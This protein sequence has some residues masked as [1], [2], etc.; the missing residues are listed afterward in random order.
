[1]TFPYICQTAV[2]IPVRVTDTVA[3][4]VKAGIFCALVAVAGFVSVAVVTL[5]V[6]EALVD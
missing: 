1:M 6:T 5:A 3:M 4:I 2:A